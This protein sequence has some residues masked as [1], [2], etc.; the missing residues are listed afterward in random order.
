MHII[1]PVDFRMVSVFVVEALFCLVLIQRGAHRR[2]PL[3]ATYAV[4]VLVMD[5]VRHA[6]RW[7]FGFHSEAYFNIYWAAQVV[8]MA[9]RGGLVVQ[10]CR[11]ILGP[12]R[13]VWKLCR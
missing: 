1:G 3:V 4:A 12:Y 13:G 8:L 6:V 11:Y 2:L 7:R 5:A 10:L 9:L